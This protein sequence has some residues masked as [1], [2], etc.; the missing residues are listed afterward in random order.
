MTDV[1][2]RQ[3]RGRLWVLLAMDA[4]DRGGIAPIPKDRFHRLI[5][6]SNCLAQIFGAD[7]PATRIIK[8]KRGPFYPDIQWEIDRLVT[9]QWLNLHGLLLEQD[10][11]GP[12]LEADYRISKRGIEIAQVL[13]KTPLGGSTT[14]YID[15]LVF[16]FAH[17]NLRKVD[18]TAL[19]ELNWQ[20]A[21]EG[22]L[23]TFEDAE[24]NLA[25]RKTAEFQ[26]LAPEILANRFREQIQ[27]YL[28]YIEGAEAAA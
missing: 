9:M 10:Q 4:C 28:R 14:A 23:I 12:W 3:L 19:K 16:A 2:A 8:Y 21:G 17:L 25:I 27:L 24:A 6:L 22:A 1:S 20:P 7:P 15:E 11:H 5:F 26:Q 18:D 13:K